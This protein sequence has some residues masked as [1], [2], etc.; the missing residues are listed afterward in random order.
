MPGQFGITQKASARLKKL[1]WQCL[2]LSCQDSLWTRASSVLATCRMHTSPSLVLRSGSLEAVSYLGWCS[3]SVHTLC[4]RSIFKVVLRGSVGE[5]RLHALHE[6]GLF[7]KCRDVAWFRTHTAAVGFYFETYLMCS[8]PCAA[9]GLV[10]TRHLLHCYIF[11]VVMA[12][13]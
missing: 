13:M 7:P 1:V 11:Q 4:P 12:W 8:H 10:N 6:M 9:S 2:L 5:S 3:L